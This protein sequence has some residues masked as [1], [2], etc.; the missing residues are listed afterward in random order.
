VNGKEV[1]MPVYENDLES[2]TSGAA[3]CYVPRVKMY[4]V[5]DDYCFEMPVELLFVGENNASIKGQPTT[6]N[7]TKMGLYKALVKLKE[8]DIAI[9]TDE[10]THLIRENC[11]GISKTFLFRSTNDRLLISP[12]SGVYNF[13]RLLN[14]F[15]PGAYE[16]TFHGNLLGKPVLNKDLELIESYHQTITTTSNDGEKHVK[17]DS[18]SS[19]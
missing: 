2:R 14:D 4:R 19:R 18:F 6:R 1:A 3:S 10:Q 7:F 17:S 9:L 12:I 16:V 13:D 15:G 8:R 5:D 11:N